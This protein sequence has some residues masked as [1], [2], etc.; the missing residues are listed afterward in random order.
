[1]ML[2]NNIDR[3]TMFDMLEESGIPY[4]KVEIANDREER[5]SSPIGNIADLFE[6]FM[7]SLMGDII[8]SGDDQASYFMNHLEVTFHSLLLL[9][10][11]VLSASGRM[12]EVRERLERIRDEGRMEVP[13][14]FYDAF[15]EPM[16]GKEER[17]E[18]GREGK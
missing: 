16:E 4:V 15:N 12:D 2:N 5:K 14:A 9:A 11:N 6:M 7:N 8:V 10:G 18:E 13:K 3:E 17:E 1:M